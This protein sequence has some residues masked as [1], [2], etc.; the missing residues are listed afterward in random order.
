MLLTLHNINFYQE[1]MSINKK[2]YQKITFDQVSRQI[3]KQVV[4]LFIHS[5]LN[6]KKNII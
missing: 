5:Y 2:K 3:Y 1:L 4:T 6:I